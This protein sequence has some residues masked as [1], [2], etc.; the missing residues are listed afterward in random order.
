MID[1]TPYD[2]A[3]NILE[4]TLGYICCVVQELADDAT[5]IE[6]E[7]TVSGGHQAHP[8]MQAVVYLVIGR[9][10]FFV[11]HPITIGIDAH[12]QLWA[13]PENNMDQKSYLSTT[14]DMLTYATAMYDN[15][16]SARTCISRTDGDRY[17]IPPTH[18]RY[19][20]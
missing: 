20:P 1:T 6:H 18:S 8:L 16:R 7:Y 3:T 14:T 15:L 10:E 17:V 5:E 2:P 12:N 13:S 19:Q 9:N 4:H 11:P